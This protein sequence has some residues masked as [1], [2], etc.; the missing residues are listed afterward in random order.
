LRCAVVSGNID[1]PLQ[2]AI[3]RV[4]DHGRVGHVYHFS[5]D[6]TFT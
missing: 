5:S 3:E 1:R 2:A 4:I 6:V